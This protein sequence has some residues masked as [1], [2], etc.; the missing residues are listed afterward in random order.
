MNI[1]M[2]L[3]NIT[4]FSNILS[5]T[6]SLIM[7]LTRG[8]VGSSLSNGE[9]ELRREAACVLET[10]TQSAQSVENDILKIM[11]LQVLPDKQSDWRGFFNFPM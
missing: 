10:S 8:Q 4:E 11:T 1:I 5:S 9:A 6:Q 3:W 7:R 2:T